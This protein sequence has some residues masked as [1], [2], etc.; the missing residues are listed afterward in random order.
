MCVCLVC[1]SFKLSTENII[2]VLWCFYCRNYCCLFVLFI[3]VY[4]SGVYVD[5]T[6][7]YLFLLLFFVICCCYY[8]TGLNL[9]DH[10]KQMLMKAFS[11]LSLSLSFAPFLTCLC[12]LHLSPSLSRHFILSRLSVYL[13]LLHYFHC[14][15]L[16]YR[17]L[18]IA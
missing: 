11:F 8:F 4:C 3:I 9:S 15:L 7:E 5:F 18:V 13:L 6:Q 16:W 2:A 1:V 12:P 10:C 14:C 17:Q